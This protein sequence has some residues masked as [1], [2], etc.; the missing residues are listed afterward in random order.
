MDVRTI[1]ILGGYGNFGKRIASHL[2]QSAGLTL[3]IGGRDAGKAASYAD[4]LQAEAAADTRVEPCRIDYK[5]EDFP[6]QLSLLAPQLVIH[7]SGP[8]QGQDYRVSEACIACGA[9]YIDLADDR[10]F[11]C[12]I[13]T[14]N[15]KAQEA[16]VLVVSGA[17]SVPG[18]SSVVVD[19]FLPQFQRLDTIDFAIAPGN[20]AERGEATLRGILSYTGHAFPVWHQGQIT[21]TH[22]WM[23]PRSR[24]FGKA[25]GKRWLADIDIPDLELFPRRYPTA[26]TVRFQAGLELPLLHFGMVGMA[27]LARLRLIPD[28]SIFIRPIWRVSEWFKRFGS[29]N[30]GMQISLTGTGK[31]NK[32]LTIQWT[33]TALDG[34]GPH[35]PT[36]SALI[37]AEK[38]IRGTTNPPGAMPCLGLYDLADFDRIADPEGITQATEVVHG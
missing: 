33:L 13:D 6:K 16:G 15:A 20:Q 35:I 4:A 11:V 9:H 21:E 5:A 24:D 7:T 38:L 14:L 3:L 25:L 22:G 31:D 18:L 17:S 19:H 36:M 23:A 2:S 30:G 27:W 34:V 37:L 28:W 8:F 29:G 32:P 12:D 26:Q 10:R 1:L